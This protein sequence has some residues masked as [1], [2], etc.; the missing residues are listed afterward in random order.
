MKVKAYANQEKSRQ[1]GRN[2]KLVK[3]IGYLKPSQSL[4]KLL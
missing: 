3:G 1:N 2:I 4:A